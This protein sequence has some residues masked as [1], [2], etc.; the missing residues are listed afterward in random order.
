MSCIGILDAIV[1]VDVNAQIVNMSEMPELVVLQS[2][3]TVATTVVWLALVLSRRGRGVSHGV[4]RV[5]KGIAF[6]AS[7]ALAI[8]AWRV[9]ELYE[10]GEGET[11]SGDSSPI[12]VWR[13]LASA[14]VVV[15]A[16]FI[17]VPMSHRLPLVAVVTV[18][19]CAAATVVVDVGLRGW[20]TVSVAAIP[21]IYAQ[22][23]C[24]TIAAL[25]FLTL[26]RSRTSRRRNVSSSRA[27]A[28]VS[29]SRAKADSSTVVA[30]DALE[31][32]RPDV[33]SSCP[34]S[35]TSWSWF[36]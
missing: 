4:Q 6:V 22:H 8:V 25:L 5:A 10:C 24:N 34:P 30:V 17:I 26:P 1:P 27:K 7:F 28:V 16:F 9:V 11:G 20:W 14:G 36:A 18:L 19:L 15:G 31:S 12:L 21:L 3:P 23:L 13:I 29:S 32:R 33:T 2:L 35:S